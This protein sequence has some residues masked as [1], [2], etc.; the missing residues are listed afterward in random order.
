[1]QIQF[2][3][4]LYKSHDHSKAFTQCIPDKLKRES[5]GKKK[6]DF[7]ESKRPY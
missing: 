2:W 5:N 1:M 6:E 7:E 3:K 4:V